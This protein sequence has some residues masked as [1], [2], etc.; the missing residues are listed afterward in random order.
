MK[1][2]LALLAVLAVIALMGWAFMYGGATV[3]MAVLRKFWS[4]M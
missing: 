2:V 1:L 4:E 3:L